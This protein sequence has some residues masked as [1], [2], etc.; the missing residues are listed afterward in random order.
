MSCQGC[1]SFNFFSGSQVFCC[2]L[3]PVCVSSLIIQIY[4]P[5]HLLRPFSAYFYSNLLRNLISFWVSKDIN[6]MLLRVLKCITYF[7]ICTLT[8]LPISILLEMIVPILKLMRLST[9]PKRTGA[10]RY[11]LSF[12]AIIE[13]RSTYWKL[14]WD[15]AQDS[16]TYGAQF[17]VS[18][19]SVCVQFLH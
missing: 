12:D 15:L 3:D 7:E 4:Q 10:V 6:L 14:S 2:I 13:L 18:P 1:R 5:P 16:M 8:N 9:L 17:S 11:F 19:V